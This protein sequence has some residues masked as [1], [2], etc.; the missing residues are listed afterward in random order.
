MNNATFRF[1]FQD[2]NLSIPQ[3][4]T[5][6]GYK[7]GEDRDLVTDLIGDVLRESSGICTIK[8]QYT[9]FSRCTILS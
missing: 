6:M 7:D 1:S 3:I 5:V 9:V 4:E 8:A 2:L